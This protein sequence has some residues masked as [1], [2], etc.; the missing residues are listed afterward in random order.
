MADKSNW[1]D[2]LIPSEEKRQA[3]DEGLDEGIL[4]SRILGEEGIDGL[5]RRLTEE[6]LLNQG[7]SEEDVRKRIKEEKKYT[8][9]SSLLPKD[10]SLFGE[11]KA[12][13]QEAK[14]EIEDIDESIKYKEVEK[15]GLGNKDDYEVG[16]GESIT[17]AVVSGGIKMPKGIINFGT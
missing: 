12:A 15:I 7:L 14:K 9:L 17:G 2:F 13:Q 6:E 1:Y 10:V 3:I 11:A 8:E 5:I 4:Y 16:L